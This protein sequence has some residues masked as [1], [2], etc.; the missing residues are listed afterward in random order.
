MRRRQFYRFLLARDFDVV[1]EK[2]QIIEV[3]ELSLTV[4]NSRFRSDTTYVPEFC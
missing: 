1:S 3:P 2:D 4:W